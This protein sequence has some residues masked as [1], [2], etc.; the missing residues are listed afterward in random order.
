MTEIEKQIHYLFLSE[1]QFRLASAVRLA[2]TMNRQPLDL[3]IEWSHGEQQIKYEEIALR[4]DQAECASEFLQ[5]SCTYIMAVT[6]KEAIKY[7]VP[8]LPDNR[9]MNYEIVI[10]T[11]KKI[12]NK[13]WICSD[14][15]VA[16]AYIIALLIRNAYTHDPISP[17]WLIHSKFKNSEFKIADIICL[18]TTELH[19]SPFNWQHYGGPLAMLR[20]SRFA[21]IN[22]LRDV[23]KP[24]L[25]GSFPS[26][27]Y[28]MYQKGNVILTEIDKRGSITKSY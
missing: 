4:Q 13:L 15:D 2:T 18:N 9:N 1:L 5:L 25:G 14:E 27:K 24:H 10:N 21:R 3:P 12:N 19:G 8:S 23:S 7:I 22:I 6:V 11:I 16:M 17:S 26:P 28:K 20:F